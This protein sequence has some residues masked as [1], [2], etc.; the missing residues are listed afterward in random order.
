M[1]SPLLSLEEA[2][3]PD[4]AEEGRRVHTILEAILKERGIDADLRYRHRVEMDLTHDWE[5]PHPKSP[6]FSLEVNIG[7]YAFPFCLEF[8]PRVEAYVFQRR[9]DGH[10]VDVFGV[11]IQGSQGRGRGNQRVVTNRRD[12]PPQAQKLETRF[13]ANYPNCPPVG[14]VGDY[15][16]AYNFVEKLMTFFFDN[17]TT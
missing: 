11:I 16:G 8:D 2:L 1:K 7:V 15:D 5:F 6:A 13:R 17:L 14:F 9:P 10:P 12:T 4:M 3:N